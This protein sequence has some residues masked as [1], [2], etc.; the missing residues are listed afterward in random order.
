LQDFDADAWDDELDG[1]GDP[2]TTW[3]TD[4][5]IR[6]EPVLSNENL[7]TLSSK[8]SKRSFDDYDLEYS[9][10][11][12]VTESPGLFYTSSLTIQFF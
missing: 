5:D 2:D 11:D 8:V 10:D 3:E 7:A 1:E 12:F 9:D 6:D 4:Q